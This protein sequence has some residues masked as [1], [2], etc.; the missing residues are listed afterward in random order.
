MKSKHDVSTIHDTALIPTHSLL[1][2]LDRISNMDWKTIIKRHGA[3]QTSLRK[4][5]ASSKGDNS[6]Y[7]L[8]PASLDSREETHAPEQP[9][10]FI[11]RL[12]VLF[13]ST[14]L[15]I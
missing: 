5:A 13:L 2:I 8:I 15:F 3:Q 6:V 14:L 12:V 9:Q 4:T 1:R 11:K 10:S 7:L